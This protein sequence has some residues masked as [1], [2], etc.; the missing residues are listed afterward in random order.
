MQIASR[1]PRLL[2]SAFLAA[3][4]PPSNSV[5]PA[6][7]RLAKPVPAAPVT[8]APPTAPAHWESNPDRMVGFA[9]NGDP[10]W[11][12][13]YVEHY[14]AMRAA[15]KVDS[16]TGRLVL[17]DRRKPWQKTLQAFSVDRTGCVVTPRWGPRD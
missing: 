4:P 3:F 11:H 7:R 16:R 5:R 1:L 14:A 13:A 10:I 12:P 9:A 6:R 15:Q 17:K 8:I 2:R